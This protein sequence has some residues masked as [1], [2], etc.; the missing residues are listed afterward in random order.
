MIYRKK[1]KKIYYSYKKL[2]IILIFIFCE[3]SFCEENIDSLKLAQIKDSLYNIFKKQEAYHNERFFDNKTLFSP[4]K[5][6]RQHFFGNDYFTYS[7]VLSGNQNFA[8]LRYSP[9]FPLNRA[10]FRGYTIPIE[11]GLLSRLYSP[12][13]PF[14]YY[15]LLE[16]KEFEIRP[17]GDISPVIFD[18]KTVTPDVF[19]AW[20]GG[21][22]N[23]NTLKFRMMRNLSDK[24]S[25]LAFISYSDLKR[26]QF[27]HGGGMAQTYK[28][29]H[30]DT[31][32][33]SINGYNP[34]SMTN[35][36]GISLDYKNNISTSLRYSYS[37]IGQDLA[38]RTDSVVVTPDS[39]LNI[40][41]NESRNYLHQIDG[42][43]EIPFGDKIL[44]RNLGKIETVKQNE[45]PISRTAR[46]R[47][48]TERS[49]RENTLQSA[50]SQLYFAPKDFDSIS[51]QFSV[52]RYISDSAGITHTVAHNT[53]FLAEN[54]F[55]SPNSDNISI[56]TN[57]GI[58][59]VRAN[60]KK[61]KNYPLGLLEIDWKINNFQTQIWGKSGFSPLVYSK[62]Y[63]N[64]DEIADGF[65]AFGANLRYQ[66]PAASINFGYSAIDAANISKYWHN[67]EPYYCPKNVFSIGANLGEIGNFSLFSNWLLSDEKPYV[68]SYS[69]LRF[70][71]NTNSQVRQFYT[72]VFYNYWSKRTKYTG[73]FL[74]DA[75]YSYFGDYPHWGRSIHDVSFKLTAEIHTFRIFWKIDN[76]LN[77][78]NSY[79][80]GYIMPGLIFRWGFSWNVLG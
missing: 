12:V 61:I 32:K 49:S 8:S 13:L 80:P 9:D 40:A 39:V 73:A 20:Q 79:I 64:Y 26:M 66:F 67:S 19:F 37:D 24:L 25:M 50:G 36:S 76:F 70:H 35:K 56:T 58:E 4:T 14:Y 31:T 30:K 43:F 46:G 45:V 33:I 71:F 29:Y 11:S 72:D 23:G 48:V 16:I 53:K 7:D 17:N 5:I 42:A 38:Y 15:D 27:Y 55:V 18:G 68:K 74:S 34:Y 77:R 65:K 51:L 41:W 22:F 6:L 60:G 63:E 54:K 28:T 69:G 52:N 10:L 62:P 2:I 44:F 47:P 59:F 21:L 57:G 75:Q 1:R 78:T 3:I